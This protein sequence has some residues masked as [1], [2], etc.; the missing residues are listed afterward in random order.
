MKTLIPNINLLALLVL[1]LF[2]TSMSC[3][4]INEKKHELPTISINIDKF[5]GGSFSFTNMA[6][7]MADIPLN[8]KLENGI[9]KIPIPD[10]L[11][12]A[13]GS[14]TLRDTSESTMM[15]S[16]L[17]L[18]NAKINLSMN[19]N[20]LVFSGSELQD[21]IGLIMEKISKYEQEIKLLST[22]TTQVEVINSMRKKIFRETL[23]F[24]KYLTTKGHTNVSSYL[25]YGMHRMNL[26]PIHIIKKIHKE[27]GKSVKYFWKNQ[28]CD[29]IINDKT[30]NI[31]ISDWNFQASANQHKIVPGTYILVD[32]WAS[33][34]G[35]CIQGIPH[36]KTIYQTYKPKGLQILSLSIDAD[37]TKWKNKSDE[38]KLPWP[39]FLDNATIEQRLSH[40]LNITAIPHYFLLNQD[41]QILARDIDAEK[42]DQ[43]LNKFLN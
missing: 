31:K 1:S 10:S 12:G 30:T 7:G 35:P 4:R 14:I 32:V 41:G 22:D 16:F 34:C 9:T 13:F 2:V 23:A 33:W 40:Q 6:T 24:S 19:E 11:L 18:D 25:I 27:C 20:V 3:S 17:F 26:L 28:L 21:S 8:G 43:I 29:L 15:G 39:S 38:L 5:Y 42:L 37:S 36:L